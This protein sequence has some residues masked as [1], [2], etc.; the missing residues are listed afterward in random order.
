MSVKLNI[1]ANVTGAGQVQKLNAGLVAT[2]AA[3]KKASKGLR[4]MGKVAQR[5]R[6]QIAG[7]ATA[8]NVGLAAGFAAVSLGAG[9]FIKDTFDAGNTVE[10]LQIRFKLLFG[11][12]EEGAKSFDTLTKF[13]AKVPFSL[14]EI[15]KGSGNLAVISKDADELNEILKVTGN[16]AAATGLD[17]Q[18][19]ATQIQRSFAGGIA[20]A[21]IFRERGVRAMLGF[22]A[23]VKVS[24]EETKKRFFEVFGKG[25][26]FGNATKELAKTLQG[27]VSMVQDKYFKFRQVVS[28]QFFGVLTKQIKNLNKELESEEEAFNKL[29]TTV[30]ENLGKAFLKIESAIRFLIENWEKFNAVIKTFIAYKVAGI[31]LTISAAVATLNATMRANPLGAFITAIQLLI[32]GFVLFDKQLNEYN[33]KTMQFLNKV[34]NQALIGVLEF[35]DALNFIPGIT[36]D[37]SDALAKANTEVTNMTNELSGLAEEWRN[38]ANAQEAYR[39]T[40][41]GQETRL[42]RMKAYKGLG[43]ANHDDGGEWQKKK[44]DRAK[45]L[46]SIN[47]QIDIMNRNYIRNKAAEAAAIEIS[48]TK[49][50]TLREVLAEMNV[51][52]KLIGDSIGT[53][54]VEGLR[55]GNGIINSTVDAFKNMINVV[56]ETIVKQ[57]IQLGVEKL[58]AMFADDKV[59]A[60]KELNKEKLKGLM[61]SIKQAAI[62]A[63]SALLSGG[64]S[65][66]TNFLG[67]NKGGIVP[68]GAPYN[69]RV[70][71]M[72][73]PGE[74]VIPRDQVGSAGKGTSYNTTINQNINTNDLN[75]ALIS[76][77]RTNAEEVNSILSQSQG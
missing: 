55:N 22:E 26:T 10:S 19:T 69:D 65:G 73:T 52:A 33:I 71:A 16:V 18:Q 64:G 44:D 39:E 32:A 17:F 8:L 42:D 3:S 7:L 2:G 43:G 28:K 51:D 37:V 4:D 75:N 40:S 60:E 59:E 6:N 24:V 14:E 72:L 57:T 63:G 11:S 31:I 41:L 27:Q 66:E 70:P 25:G 48:I 77:I 1:K 58:F 23:G 5:G 50:K 30:G 56:A 61:I 38:A 29:A 49:S 9:K 36:I 68:G 35:V 74:V 54:W 12:V 46:M 15:S 53:T 21:D 47:E 62:D 45:E 67:F 76:A 20:S 13:A 34:Y